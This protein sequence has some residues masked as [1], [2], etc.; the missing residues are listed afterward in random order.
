MV[1][2]VGLKVRQLGI[3]DV[4]VWEV[5][6]KGQSRMTPRCPTWTT[7]CMGYFFLGWGGF[8]GERCG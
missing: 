5:K 8:V 4:R 1:K 3:I 6:E 2:G 7:G